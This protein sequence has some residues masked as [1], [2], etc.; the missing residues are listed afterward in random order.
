MTT[1]IAVANWTFG[2]CLS[3][4]LMGYALHRLLHS[5][6]IGFLSR[7]HMQ[8]HLVQYG[9]LEQQ[10][11]ANYRDAIDQRLALGNIGVEWLMPAALLLIVAL[12]LFRIL[13]IPLLYQVVY[14][15]CTLGWSFLMF[16]YLHDVMHVEGFWLEKTPL[17]KRWFAGA[18]RRHDIHHRALNDQ[19]IMNKNFG[20]GLFL[21]D[22]LFGSHCDVEPGFNPTGY[23]AAMERF[24]NRYKMRRC[25]ERRRANLVGKSNFRSASLRSAI[26]ADRHLGSD[27]QDTS[28]SKA[29]RA[30]H[31]DS[32]KPMLVPQTIDVPVTSSISTLEIN[33][34]GSRRKTPNIVMKQI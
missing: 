23:Q 24:R 12:V 31:L 9:P 19:G 26:G 20:I 18:R 10:R 15:G 8:H 14:V 27:T 7:S 28:Q 29:C 13:G 34:E 33:G 4:E 5:G 22:R 2:S 11:S 30:K 16:S 25:F 17:L 3:A 21:F 6:A 1:L 32:R